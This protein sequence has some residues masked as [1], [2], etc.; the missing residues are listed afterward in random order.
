MRTEFQAHTSGLADA[1]SNSDIDKYL[2]R[3]YRF[4]LPSDVDGRISEIIWSGTMSTSTSLVAIPDYVVSLNTPKAWM[5]DTGSTTP[6]PLYMTDDYE[7]FV[8]AYP[9]FNSASPTGK[10]NTVATYGG[11]IAFNVRP[12]AAYSFSV[13]CRGGSS[14]ALDSNGVADEI[15]ALSVVTG[16]AWNYLLEKEDE[17]GA[18]R[19]GGQ[20]EIYKGMLNTRSGSRFQR[21]RPAR[22]F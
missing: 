20:Y 3:F 5:Y 22:T 11:S 9:D 19:E 10:P 18:A 16:A 12:D 4:V 14:S 17:A 6:I 1:L 8:S 21:R 2:N 13:Q 7:A 15:H